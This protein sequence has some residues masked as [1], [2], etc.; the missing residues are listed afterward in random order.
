VRTVLIRVLQRNERP[1]G[2]KKLPLIF[3]LPFSPSALSHSLAARRLATAAPTLRQA[4]R[5][6]PGPSPLAGDEHPPGS[7]APAFLPL[8]AARIRAPQPYP[9]VSYLLSAFRSTSH[10]P[11]PS[12]YT[13]VVVE[14]EPMFPSISPN[15]Y[16]L[17]KII[18]FLNED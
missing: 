12:R 2:K 14:N 16:G 9:N 7:S 13:W 11:V 3:L 5:A 8:H 4:P 6:S 10:G 17:D 15:M 18:L 1:A